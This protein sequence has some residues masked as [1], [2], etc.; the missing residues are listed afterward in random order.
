MQNHQAGQLVVIDEKR[1]TLKEDIPAKHQFANRDLKY[2]EVVTMHGVVVGKVTQGIRQGERIGTHNLTHSTAGYAF[3]NQRFS[4]QA[5]D[6]SSWRDKTFSGY[7]REDGQVGTANYWLIVPLVF[8]ENENV[9]AL[10]E[11]FTKALGYGKNNHH[12]LLLDKLITAFRSNATEHELLETNISAHQ[13]AESETPLFSNLDGIKFLTHHLGC[14]GTRRDAHLLCSLLA[15]YINHPNVAGATVLSLGC[16]NAQVAILNEEISKRNPGFSKPL[17]I[18]E[19]QA[20]PSE[21]EMIAAAIR[22]TFVGLIEANKSRRTGMPLSKLVIGV[23]CG[24][25]DGFSGISANPV[26]GQVADITVACGGS[27]ILAEFPEFCG[28]EQCL[29]D[30]CIDEETARR[31]IEIYE[32]YQSEAHA[33]GARFDM[34][35]SPGNIREGLITDAIK[36]AGA[37]KKGGTSAV[38]GVLDYPH[39]VINAGLNL[40]CTP[41][42]DVE[43]TTAIAAAGANVILFSTGLGTPTGNPIVPVV[44]ISSNTTTA[45]RMAD[46]IDFD[47][48]SIISG[49]ESISALGDE[50]FEFTVDIASNR[51]VAK[52][53]SLGHDEFIPWKR[54]VSL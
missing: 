25:S 31:F 46:I 26:M 29:L 37:I 10:K 44:K 35:P 21:E 12:Q 28:A 4:W 36:S 16:Q 42:G 43:S 54:D 49:E 40:L 24:G 20:H 8:C 50:L 34:N 27:V 19:Q 9:L 2:G 51:K 38:V 15:G 18:F 13:Q 7:V 52:A 14:G 45:V 23:E 5:P 30:R 47:A 1:I 33:T 41:G 3:R 53:V 6:I 17:F 32:S 11:V 48:G 22:K 39:W